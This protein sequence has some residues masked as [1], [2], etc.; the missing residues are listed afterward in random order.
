VQFIKTR[1]VLYAGVGIRSNK[2]T[3]DDWNWH[4]L[5]YGTLCQS[6]HADKAPSPVWA[7][8]QET[9]PYRTLFTFQIRPPPAC[10]QSGQQKYF[11]GEMK[12][13]KY[14][15]TTTASRPALGPTQP[16]I[17]WVTGVLFL[18]VKR[19]AREADH[20]SPSSADV[21]ERLEL[22]LHSPNTPSWCGA[23]LK[24]RD[25][26]TFTLNTRV[27]PKVYGMAAWS[28]NCK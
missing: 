25:N 23:W 22:Y 21:K 4:R 27:Y 9:Y 18:G 16:P 19:P 10:L 2:K 28:E 11:N 3:Q 1:T 5:H 17:Q 7:H 15:L 14:D 6:T 13:M 12:T 8:D 24:T 20:S 26:L